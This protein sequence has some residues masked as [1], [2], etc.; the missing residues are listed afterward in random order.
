MEAIGTTTILL[1]A[2]STEHNNVIL[3][4]EK[5]AHTTINKVSVSESK[6]RSRE[7]FNKLTPEV[8]KDY[9]TGTER[10]RNILLHS[11]EH[12]APQRLSQRRYQQQLRRA[13]DFR[14]LPQAVEEHWTG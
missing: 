3:F 8:E 11:E 7:T 9:V 1:F 14:A 5:I 6:K 4:V 13:L 2:I 12:S 10:S